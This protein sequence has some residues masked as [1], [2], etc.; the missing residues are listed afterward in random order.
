MDR[1]GLDRECKDL[2]LII[3]DLASGKETCEIRDTQYTLN[4]AIDYLR[5]FL[6]ELQALNEQILELGNT[7]EILK[8]V[9]DK[10]TELWL[11][12]VFFYV[13]SLPRVIRGILYYPAEEWSYD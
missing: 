2:A 12:Q 4:E 11:F 1:L 13:E 10:Y 6:Q 7:P 9:H 3:D 8:K 5:G